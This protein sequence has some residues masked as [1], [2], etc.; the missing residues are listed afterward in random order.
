MRDARD[1]SEEAVVLW[2]EMCRKTCGVVRPDDMLQE[3]KDALDRL[4]SRGVVKEI[5]VI[6]FAE[7]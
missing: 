7:E 5:A 3:H 1:R 4:L 2:V 6:V